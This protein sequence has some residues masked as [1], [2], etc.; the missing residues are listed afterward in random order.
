VLQGALALG[1]GLL[2][3]TLLVGCDSSTG[4]S[5]SSD[6]PPATPGAGSEVAEAA[7]TSAKLPQASVQ[8]QS[9]PKGDQ[10]CNGCAHF[11]PESNTCKLVE[12]R[13]NPNGWCKLWI[14]KA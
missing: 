5:P 13:I 4:S 3:P 7:A 6:Q 2:V 10:S 1:S 14:R 8:Y 9:Q 12:G 11:I